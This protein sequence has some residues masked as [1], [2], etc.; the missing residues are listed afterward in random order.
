M[1]YGFQPDALM[2][3][4]SRPTSDIFFHGA[5]NP[6]R[7]AALCFGLGIALAF[8]GCLGMRELVVSGRLPLADF[9]SSWYSR[10]SGIGKSLRLSVS[11]AQPFSIAMAATIVSDRVSV[12]PLRAQVFFSLPAMRALVPLSS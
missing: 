6:I 7:E 5:P 11:S 10:T 1:G 12:W 8:L 3:C 9:Y 4:S 2:T